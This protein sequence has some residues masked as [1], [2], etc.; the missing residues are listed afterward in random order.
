MSH[1]DSLVKYLSGLL[2]PLKKQQEI[3]VKSYTQPRAD[4][5]VR[6]H[7]RVLY[8]S[9]PMEHRLL[10]D[11]CRA[12][13][14]KFCFVPSQ[15]R[16]VVVCVTFL[17]PASSSEAGIRL[18]CMNSIVYLGRGVLKYLLFSP[19]MKGHFKAFLFRE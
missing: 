13:V 16:A 15:H 14:V 8:P 2:V 11:H 12:A 3:N 18:L 6:G 17:L 5:R 1:F 4:P 9:P 19:R 10:H 7:A